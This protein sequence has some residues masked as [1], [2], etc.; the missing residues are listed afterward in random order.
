[1]LGTHDGI[2]TADLPGSV[3]AAALSVAVT[4]T[5]AF[6]QVQTHELLTQE[7]LGQTLQM[8]QNGC[9]PTSGPA[10]R[11]RGPAPPGAVCRDT[12]SQA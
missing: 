9:R 11:H 2:A 7:Q 3:S 5:G 4:S 10:S 12:R 1:M 6:K 8:A